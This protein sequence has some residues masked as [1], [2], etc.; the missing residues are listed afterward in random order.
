MKQ[1]VIISGKGGTGK[2]VIA[3]SFAALAKN[4]VM[5][6]CDVDAA[7]LH[8]LLH[9]EVLDRHDFK[10]GKKAVIDRERCSECGKCEEVC[11]FNAIENFVVDSVSCEGCGV[12]SHI[13]PEDAIKMEDNLSGEWFISRTKYGPLVHAKLGIAE[14]NSGK[15]VTVVRQNAKLIAEREKKDFIIIDGPPGI[16]CPVIASLTGVDLALVVTEPTLSGIHDMERVCSVA[17]HFGV[18]IYVCINKYDLNLENSKAIERYCLDSD[19][20]IGGEIPFDQ[21][22]NEALVRGVPVVEN[23]DNKVTQEIKNLWNRIKQIN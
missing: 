16:G 22:V 20:E 18:K 21:A 10:G 9:P 15:L 5:A 8:L 12:C 14:E 11:R 3:A 4:K 7:D 23:S 19:I 13:C 1:I 6:D 17:R 2:T